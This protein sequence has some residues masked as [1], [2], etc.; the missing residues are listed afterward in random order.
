MIPPTFDPTDSEVTEIVAPDGSEVQKVREPDGNV[1]FSAAPAIPDSGLIR[2]YQ[3]NDDSDTTTATDSEGSNDGT[4]NG[5]SYTTSSIEGGHA[6]SFDGTDDYVSIPSFSQFGSYTIVSWLYKDTFNAIENAW[7]FQQNN[8]ISLRTRN[9]TSGG[10][11]VSNGI[12]LTHN[13][14]STNV[15]AES[16]FDNGRYQ[17]FAGTWDGSTVRI[18][19]DENDLITEKDSVSMSAMG[20]RARGT[21]IGRNDDLA[22]RNWTGRQDDYL[23][24][25]RAL[26]QSELQQIYDSV[27]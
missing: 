17:M 14:G 4:I 2:R 10:R 27:A 15:Y 12:E 6:L 19:R 18:Y 1:V 26:S 25:N 3:F 5:A 21:A 20:S 22:S 7:Y 16:E 23:I 13:D 8:G 9:T 24:Y 11:A